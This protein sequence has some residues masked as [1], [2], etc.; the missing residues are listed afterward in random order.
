MMTTMENLLMSR[1]SAGAST[2]L[3]LNNI[4]QGFQLNAAIPKVRR[5]FQVPSSEDADSAGSAGFPA[6]NAG[7]GSRPMA[8]HSQVTAL[9]LVAESRPELD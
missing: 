5:V 6:E 9:K 7:I 4:V 1:S 2:R 8:R 3:R